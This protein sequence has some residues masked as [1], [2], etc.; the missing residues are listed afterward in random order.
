MNRQHRES[1]QQL[2]W[3]LWGLL[4]G[5]GVFAGVLLGLI[6][7]SSLVPALQSGF[8]LPLFCLIVCPLAAVVA[9]LGMV[10]MHFLGRHGEM[11]VKTLAAGLFVLGAVL[12]MLLLFWL[13]GF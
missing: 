10:A 13:R 6:L 4:A 8:L 3:V 1:P 7:S 5:A 11:P 2:R 9:S 12:G